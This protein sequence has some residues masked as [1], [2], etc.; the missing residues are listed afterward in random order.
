MPGYDGP[1]AP[2]M[3][4]N[5]GENP[6]ASSS[7]VNFNKIT[8]RI[9]NL[10]LNGDPVGK[11]DIYDYVKALLDVR[12]GDRPTA[13]KDPSQKPTIL[14][15]LKLSIAT[16]SI[17][18]ELREAFKEHIPFQ[19][20][21]F[22]PEDERKEA[23]EQLGFVQQSESISESLRRL[24]QV[25]LDYYNSERLKEISGKCYEAASELIQKA[26]DP[27]II[28]FLGLYGRILENDSISADAINQGLLSGLAKFGPPLNAN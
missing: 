14:D 13:D 7:Y 20:T 26:G 2:M 5:F 6:F 19:A 1:P 11:Q 18:E 16:P 17:P 9:D 12:Q 4:P 27:S 10:V 25:H 23:L 3:P 24:L 8:A 21:F 28:L 15:M 22:I